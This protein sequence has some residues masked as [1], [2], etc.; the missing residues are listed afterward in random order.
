M[1]NSRK[2]RRRKV[3]IEQG[4]INAAIQIVEKKGFSGLLVTE[5]A[6]KA[7]I[8]PQVFYNR[9]ADLDEFIDFIVKKYDYWFSDIV[10]ENKNITDPK[11]KYKNIIS[12]L[13]DSLSQNKMMQ[14]LLIWELSVKT[15]SSVR[16]AQLREFYTMPLS[17]EYS[18][19]FSQSSIDIAALS[20]LIVSGLYYLILHA[21]LAS[22]SGVD[23]KSAEG[24]QRIYNAIDCLCDFLFSKIT[25][26]SEVVEIA[27]KMKL[28]GI[29]LEI[30]IDCTG[31]SRRVIE[32]L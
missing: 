4:I 5:L 12:N 27:R 2:K 17:N 14:Q 32:E 15:D 3:D 26:S 1:E 23:V 19:L 20:A 6:R 21:D 18:R 11:D 9:Y 31:L 25:P 28:K 30:I 22:F 16:T 8:T 29:D 7:N 24:K 13:F 10:T